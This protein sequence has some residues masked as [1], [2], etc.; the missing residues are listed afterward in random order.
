MGI[1]S[2]PNGDI[3]SHGCRSEISRTSN[4]G[5]GTHIFVRMGENLNR[6]ILLAVFVLLPLFIRKE[7]RDAESLACV[8]RGGGRRKEKRKKKEGKWR[9]GASEKS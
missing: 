4:N 2:H 7:S 5:F 1:S 6:K 8:T 9:V 3:P